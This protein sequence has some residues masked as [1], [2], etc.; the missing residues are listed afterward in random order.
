MVNSNSGFKIKYD[1]NTIDHL[2]IKLYSAFPP[3]LAELISNAYDADAENVK[4]RIDYNNKTVVISDDGEG[5]NHEELNNRYLVIGRNRRIQDNGLSSVKNRK[6]TGKKGLG[7]LA[8]FGIANEIEVSSVKDGK[9]NSFVLNYED[10][11][12]SEEDEYVPKTL[13]ED[14][15]TDKS[16]GTSIKISQIKQKNIMQLKDLAVS[17]SKRFSFNDNDFNIVLE[18]INDGQ[19]IPL[20]KELYIESIVKE[21]EWIFPQ[22]FQKDIEKYN[23]L[24]R[25]NDLG[26]EGRIYTKATPMHKNDLG[27]LIYVR[28]KLASE[29]TF[30]DSRSNDN[31]YSYVA[32]YFN[33]DYIDEDVYNDF[34]STARQSILWEESD[35]TELLRNDLKKLI[36]I[37]A[38]DWREK[39]KTKKE[40]EL[41]LDDSFFI[42]LTELEKSEIKK[43]KNILLADEYSDP[44]S[45]KRILESVKTSFKFESF[46]EYISKLED[47][48]ELTAENIEKIADDWE[49]IESKE[50]AK[51]AVGRIQAIEQFEKFINNDESESKII[52]PFLEKFPWLLD[53]RITTFEREVTFKKILKENFPDEKLSVNDRRIDFLCNLVNGELIII[54]LKRPRI[55]ISQKEVD[56]ALA[57]K[58]FIQDHYGTSV[59]KITTYLISNRYDMSRTVK[60]IVESLENNGVL[61]IKSYSDLLTEAKQFN[62]EFIKKYHEVKEAHE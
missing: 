60:T 38:L 56:Q 40:S 51:V 55:K 5:M 13:L 29:N 58:E 32:G 14:N 49:Y 52:Q 8:T 3:V 28:S 30:F 50:L 16:S 25:L 18:N 54:E 44:T 6:V 62:Q 2:G 57:Y 42:G 47:N 10:L 35:K 24:R 43:I 17:L 48:N 11:K 27:F 33:I 36:S 39:R 46:K 45:I 7:K 20:T 37:I 53:P 19:S 1:R 59:T 21:F 34:I 61:Y 31:F 26:V 12:N 4:I 15:P 41:E 22:D 23:E 9:E